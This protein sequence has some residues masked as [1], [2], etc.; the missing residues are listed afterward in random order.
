[1][2]NRADYRSY[3]GDLKDAMGISNFFSELVS[4][5]NSNVDVEYAASIARHISTALESHDWVKFAD[6]KGAI[7]V[8]I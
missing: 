1:M 6:G 8:S 4:I 3:W 2:G 7:L 5:W